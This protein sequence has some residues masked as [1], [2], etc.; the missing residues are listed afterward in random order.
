[1]D[2]NPP[3]HALNWKGE[4]WD[5]SDGTKGAHPEFPVH[6]AG[7]TTAPAL[8]S[9]FENP[10]GVPLSAIIFGGRRAKTAPLVY[11][12]C[13]WDHGVFVGS[14][15]ASETTAAA[16]GAVGVVAPRPHGNAAL[17]RLSHG[18]LLRALDRYGQE[19]STTTRP[20]SLMSTGSGP[21][22]KASSSGRD[23]A[24]IC[25]YLMWILDRC[26][27]KVDAQAAPIGWLPYAK[28]IDT[29][30]LAIEDSV[31]DDLLSVDKRL[32]EAEIDG[33]EEFYAKFDR[34]PDKLRRELSKL[35]SRIESL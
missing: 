22:T 21:M 6:R 12:S 24:T 34:L 30:G 11:Q 1:M 31:M 19:A 8:S 9:E 16:T 26:E 23:S 13:D 35:R 28:D 10:Q 25:A 33:I 20:R 18:R 5:G 15:M 4:P 7:A 29:E 27:G 32:W 14:I 2:K 17:L 3:K